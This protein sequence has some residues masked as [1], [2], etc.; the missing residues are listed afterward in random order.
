MLTH[1]YS[2]GQIGDKPRLTNV[3]LIKTRCSQSELVTISAR[4]ALLMKSLPVVTTAS[5]RSLHSNLATG[6]GHVAPGSIFLSRSTPDVLV[7]AVKTSLNIAFQRHS[8]RG[9]S[10][11]PVVFGN[12]VRV[13]RSQHIL[14]IQNR[15]LYL[16][17]RLL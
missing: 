15:T 14:L 16:P 13:N 12:E 1:L 4:P 9:L 11:E 6:K 7:H 8:E 17:I 5:V 3:N 10:P 2:S